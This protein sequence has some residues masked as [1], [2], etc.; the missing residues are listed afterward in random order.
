MKQV[1]K[2]PFESNSDRVKELR[3]QYVQVC[4]SN[5]ITAHLLY[6]CKKQIYVFPGDYMSI[7]YYTLEKLNHLYVYSSAVS[8]WE[9]SMFGNMFSFF[10]FYTSFGVE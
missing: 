8:K 2:V 9:N 1:Y 5:T 10:P 7:Y 6:Y 3:F 4:E